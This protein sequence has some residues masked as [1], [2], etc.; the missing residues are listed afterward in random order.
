MLED[1]ILVPSLDI[2]FQDLNYVL[3]LRQVE[4]STNYNLDR[5]LYSVEFPSVLK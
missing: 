1:L 4:I 2:M 5:I 3:S